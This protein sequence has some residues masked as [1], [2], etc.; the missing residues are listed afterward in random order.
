[1]LSRI[2]LYIVVQ[3]LQIICNID[4]TDIKYHLQFTSHTYGNEGES[5]L[6]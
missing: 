1:M 5:K 2:K 4:T 3:I 6:M